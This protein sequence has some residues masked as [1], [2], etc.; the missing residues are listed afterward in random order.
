M[1]GVVFTQ[2][3]MTLCD[4]TDCS[5]SGFSIHGIC[6]TRRV[7]WVAIE[8]IFLTQRSV[9]SEPQGKPQESPWLP[10][11]ILQNLTDRNSNNK[12]FSWGHF[13]VIFLQNPGGQAEHLL[14]SVNTTRAQ[15][16][17][18]RP[19]NNGMH[20]RALKPLL[21]RERD[22]VEKGYSHR[23]PALKRLESCPR[24]QG[25]HPLPGA[26]AIPLF[27]PGT[28]CPSVLAPLGLSVLLLPFFFLSNSQ[29]ILKFYSQILSLK[30]STGS[31]PQQI[32][33]F[34]GRPGI[35]HLNYFLCRQVLWLVVY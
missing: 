14:G 11:T 13:H 12:T 31:V 26:W 10:Y 17:K 21:S 24:Q 32:Y 28:L 22:A 25:T 5:L 6:Q 27:F 7:E 18:L 3:C 19:Q 2:S 9:P 8:G 1:K 35:L 20:G 29:N 4:P 16:F 33:V 34:A 30:R 23:T 15:L